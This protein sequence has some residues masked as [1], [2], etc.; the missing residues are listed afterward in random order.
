M[1][2]L[3]PEQEWAA[4]NRLGRFYAAHVLALI[5]GALAFAAGI[6]LEGA[7]PAFV[8]AGVAF[9]VAGAAALAGKRSLVTFRGG[10]IARGLIDHDAVAS[11]R[12]ERANAWVFGILLITWGIALVVFAVVARTS[13]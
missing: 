10:T 3:E 4:A 13:T 5:V 7:L 6:A 11:A 1:P 8:G 12:F 2:K 9:V